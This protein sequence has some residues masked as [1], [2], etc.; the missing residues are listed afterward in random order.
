MQPYQPGPRRRNLRETRRGVPTGRRATRSVIT[1]YGHQ[2]RDRDWCAAWAAARNTAET[3]ELIVSKLV[4]KMSPQAQAAADALARRY[5]SHSD[6]E[7]P[8]IAETLIGGRAFITSMDG[9][10]LAV[11]IME[12]DENGPVFEV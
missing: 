4:R 8:Q 3:G 6:G 5:A 2:Q 12:Q 9:I 1:A 7:E 10:K 11:L